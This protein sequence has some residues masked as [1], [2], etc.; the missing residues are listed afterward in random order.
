MQ[1]VQNQALREMADSAEF[2]HNLD[3]PLYGVL[4]YE[5]TNSFS[6]VK[7]IYCFASSSS[8]RVQRVAFFLLSVL[9]YQRLFGQDQGKYVREH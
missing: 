4:T 8:G 9:E 5:Q 6:I 3:P 7:G 1:N 2:E